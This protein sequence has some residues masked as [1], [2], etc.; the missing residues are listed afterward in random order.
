M[1]MIFLEYHKALINYKLAVN[2]V[3]EILED[4]L[5]LFQKTQPQSPIT[6]SE[7]VDGGSPK[8]KQEEY[9]IRLE[10]K[11]IRKRFELAKEI[12]VDSWDL[13][14]Q[15]ELELRHSKGIKDIVYCMKYVDGKDVAWI[16]TEL[17]YSESHV[18]RII[19]SIEKMIG[20]DRK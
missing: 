8:N 4:K 11:Q 1:G 9:V 14:Q 12:M 19:K 10:E 3:E 13:L 18:Y 16:A 2:A 15:K 20:N 7:R 6:G 5:E 17:H